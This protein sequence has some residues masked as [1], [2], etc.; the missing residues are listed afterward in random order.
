VA[1]LKTN[2]IDAA[3]IPGEKGQFDVLRDGE[4]V[5]SK[6][7]TGRFPEQGEILATLKA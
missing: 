3:D 2:G 6:Q 7:E 1:E 5:F 4:L